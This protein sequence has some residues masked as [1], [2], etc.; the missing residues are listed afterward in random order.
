MKPKT[1]IEK[2][3]VA[4]SRSMK[5][6]TD[7]QIEWMRKQ[8]D[9]SS[10]H[11]YNGK[12]ADI[13]HY[14]IVTVKSGWQVLRHYYSYVYFKRKKY[15]SI[16]V[17]LVMEEW[18][19]D[20]QYVFLSLTRQGLGGVQDAW[21]MY[22]E[23]EVR[24]GEC[25]GYFLCDPRS[26]GYSKVRYVRLQEPF[27]YI[28]RDEKCDEHI[29]RMFRA[30]NT[31]PFNET[32]YKQNRDAWD[33][34]DRNDFI[35]DAEKTA[36]LKIA[37]R[38]GYDYR[39]VEWRDMIDNLHYLKKDLHN[40]TLVCPKDLHEAH[41]RWL[42]AAM[43]KK[44][45]MSERMSRLRQ[46]AEE[47]ARLRRMQMEA[48]FQERRKEEAKAAI[49]YYEKARKRFFGLVIAD[50]NLEITVLKSVQEFMEEGAAMQHCVF[51]NGYYD[52]K[53]RPY[54]LILSARVDGERAETIEVNLADYSIVQSRGKH[55]M[56]T[57]YHERIIEI[58]K[59][60]MGR[61]KSLNEKRGHAV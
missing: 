47:R 6:V 41:D 24:R 27:R 51:G 11:R 48:E 54:C 49:P 38:H 25:E 21:C 20:G 39:H 7:S 40:P 1:K 14:I 19:K 43:R 26:L 61:I 46:L 44:T 12:R 29:G 37:I 55:N 15:D 5:R 50:E 31:S 58:M 2:E 10:T 17:R 36:A 22:G 60:N 28:P 9:Y 16:N 33:W 59:E 56:P 34:S 35:Y 18:F 8:A 4:L 57:P 3:V 53:K 52:V 23:L 13:R 45:K 42:A 30:L 32:L